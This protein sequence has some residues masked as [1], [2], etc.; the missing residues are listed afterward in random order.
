MVSQRL[1]AP[2]N[3]MKGVTSQS[4]PV[5]YNVDT[6]DFTIL[7]DWGRPERTQ[8]ERVVGTKDTV[9]WDETADATIA[10]STV[11][12]YAYDRRSK[13]VTQLAK[14]SEPDG[15][16][17]VCGAELTD[18]FETCA[19]V[20]RPTTSRSR[21]PCSRSRRSR[22]GRRSSHRSRPAHTTTRC[23]TTW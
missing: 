8:I 15:L 4:H 17:R 13:V 9:V 6:K 1:E 7:D 23:R 19:W 11:V 18:T 12:I 20:I 16:W 10:S 2:T 5:M 14:I 21:T 3:D 22:D